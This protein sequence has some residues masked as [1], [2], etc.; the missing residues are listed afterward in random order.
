M[1]KVLIGCG[2]TSV[3][4]LIIIVY[5]GYRVYRF[6]QDIGFQ[7]KEVNEQYETLDVQIPFTEPEDGLI[8]PHRFDLWIQ[9]RMDLSE[10]INGMVDSIGNFSIQTIFQIREQTFEMADLFAGSLETAL[11]SPSEYLWITRQVVGVLNSGDAQANPQMDEI[12]QAFQDLSNDDGSTRERLDVHSLEEP[13][14]Y[15]QII[16]TCGLLIG[17]KEPFLSS[18]HVFYADLALMVLLEN[19]DQENQNETEATELF[20]ST[21]ISIQYN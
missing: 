20:S 21:Q 12:I 2:V 13:V 16:R 9:L 3:I 15:D 10:Q 14:T 1:K 19:D 8:P 4:I 11:M 18:I 17:K 5:A 7:L 6:A